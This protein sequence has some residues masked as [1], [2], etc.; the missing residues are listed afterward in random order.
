MNTS[1]LN[2]E[3]LIESF[4]GVDRKELAEKIG[5]SRNT[6]DQIARGHSITSAMRAKL[7]EHATNGRVPATVLRPDIFT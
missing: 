1:I 6:I 7:I 5:S 2:K 3:K 4:K